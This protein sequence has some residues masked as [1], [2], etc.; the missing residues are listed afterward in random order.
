MSNW[1]SRFAL[2]F[3]ALFLGCTAEPMS[4]PLDQVESQIDSMEAIESQIHEVERTVHERDAGE[5]VY[6][7]LFNERDAILDIA[8]GGYNSNSPL[9][10]ALIR[11]MSWVVLGELRKRRPDFEIRIQRER[12]VPPV[13]E[14]LDD[15]H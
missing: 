1:F 8:E 12:N 5:R 11:E 2:F 13:K 14:G 6:H 15:G 4:D 3:V 10:R 7:H 9:H